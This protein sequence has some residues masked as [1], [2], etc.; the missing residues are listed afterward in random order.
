MTVFWKVHECH[1]CAESF[2]RPCTKHTMRTPRYAPALER[3]HVRPAALTRQH[4]GV[5]C[6]RHSFGIVLATYAATH[7]RYWCEFPFGVCIPA[8]LFCGLCIQ[9]VVFLDFC[10]RACLWLRTG[11]EC[12][13]CLGC[14]MCWTASKHLRWRDTTTSLSSAKQYVF[15]PLISISVDF[16]LFVAIICIDGNIMNKP[17]TQDPKSSFKTHVGEGLCFRHT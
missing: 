3:Y 7:S 4:V 10:E 1:F 15:V 8:S 14:K 17:I 2:S 16:N 11:S 13:G 5:L 9:V 6:V 12:R